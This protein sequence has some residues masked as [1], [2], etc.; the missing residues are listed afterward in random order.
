MIN[1]KTNKMLGIYL[2][3]LNKQSNINST[4]SRFCLSSVINEVSVIE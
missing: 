3:L 4:V 2:F 1:T